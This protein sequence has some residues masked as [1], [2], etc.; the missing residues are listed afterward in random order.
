MKK[1]NLATTAETGMT[2][3]KKKLLRLLGLSGFVFFLV[4]GL[5][6]LVLLLGGGYFLGK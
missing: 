6:W 4:K 3:R 1:G 2:P 5:V